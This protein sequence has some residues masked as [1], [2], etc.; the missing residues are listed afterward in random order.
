MATPGE[1]SSKLLEERELKEL[2]PYALRSSERRD[3]LKDNFRQLT[4][5]TS[6]EYRTEYHRDRDRIVWSKSFKRLQ[7][8]TQIFPHYFEDHYRRR[9]THSLEVAQIA[10]TLARALKLNE[11]AAEA[12]ALGH[13]LGHTPFG[14][15]GERA[16]SKAMF[17]KV[18]EFRKN[19]KLS[20]SIPI[21]G[22]DHCAHA[23]EVVSYIEKEY[24]TETDSYG[25][26][27]T[28]DVR[29][30]I[31]KHIYDYDK[32]PEDRPLSQVSIITKYPK[33]NLYGNNKGSLEAQCV[34]F[35][36]KVAY[37]L[38]DIE[39]GIRSR[40]LKESI[41]D[42]T[43]FFKLLREH[44]K[45]YRGNSDLHLKKIED[46]TSFRS[47]A[48]S[49]LILDCIETADKH[50]KDYRIQ[51]TDDVFGNSK[52]LVYSSDGLAKSW[53]LFYDEWMRNCL[54]I[55]DSVIACSFKAD[56]II[57]D[58][59][60]AYTENESLIRSTYREDC[61]KSYKS[62]GITDPRIL[63]LIKIRNYIAGMT[64]AYAIDHHASLYSSTERIILA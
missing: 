32:P 28:F 38:G 5:K 17:K 19:S 9:L 62:I 6:L 52:R 60:K 31:L 24:L 39:D 33:F 49:V 58:L 54:F 4:I 34:Y 26:D 1:N 11:I 22:F 46:F 61:E 36:D 43:E 23:V 12:I 30:G 56:K 59:F 41:L 48:L 8:K 63:K 25:L 35:A 7:H 40:I 45:K 50:I 3:L 53:D 37:L 57:N 21:E 15:A 27:L 16:L 2:K 42:K 51:T 20:F 64:D 18:E 14:H 13:D 10:T 55:N 44:Y 29:D 47:K